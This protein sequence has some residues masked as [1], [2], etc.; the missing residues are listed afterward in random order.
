MV[1]KKIKDGHTEEDIAAYRSTFTRFDVDG[2]G[3]IDSDELGKMIRV[4]G[5]KYCYYN[6]IFL[7]CCQA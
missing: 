5:Y 4:L 3:A 1:A 7:S 2:G 6:E